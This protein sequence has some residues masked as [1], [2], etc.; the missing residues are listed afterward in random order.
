MG[1]EVLW[2]PGMSIAALEQLVIQKAYR[3][4]RQN[5]TATA[6]S[7]G[8]SIRTLDNK[9]EKYEL[10]AMAQK[11]RDA[12]EE[13]RRADF[14]AR[15]RGIAPAQYDSATGKINSVGA[16][17]GVHVQSIANATPQQS[18]P[19]PERKEVQSVLPTKATQSGT[20]RSSR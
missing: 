7:L 19:L 3:F 12:E 17:A 8:I 14:L 16:H 2:S 18:M 13:Q 1:N 6:N 11:D 15:S 20:K 4:Y 9:L 10:E 5:K